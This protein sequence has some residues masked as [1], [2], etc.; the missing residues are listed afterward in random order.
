MVWTATPVLFEFVS[1][2]S[3]VYSASNCSLIIKDKMEHIW[4]KEI[5]WG[6]KSLDWEGG[7]APAKIS[8]LVELY[9]TTGKAIFSILL[10]NLTFEA[11]A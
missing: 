9:L 8:A 7:G 6:S 10:S 1:G 5:E 4:I 3:A 2:H 11:S